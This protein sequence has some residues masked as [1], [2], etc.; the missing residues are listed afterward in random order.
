MFK[1]I[2]IASKDI[3]IIEYILTIFFEFIGLY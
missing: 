3:I 1:L 2:Y